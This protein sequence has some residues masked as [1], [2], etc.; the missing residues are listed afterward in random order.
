MANAFSTSN[1][2]GDRAEHS[3]FELRVAEIVAGLGE[4]HLAALPHSQTILIASL[5]RSIFE[6]S[7]M[8]CR[9][10]VCAR[11]WRVCPKSLRLLICT[12]CRYTDIECNVENEDGELLATSFRIT[13]DTSD[14]L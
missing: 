8:G 11:V 10:K 2:R 12:Q 4:Q 13:N 6:G 5:T 14:S 1:A 3:I 9:L 7:F